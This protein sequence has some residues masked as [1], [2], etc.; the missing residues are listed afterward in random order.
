MDDKIKDEEMLD[1]QAAAAF[2]NVSP[3]TLSVWRSTGRYALPFLKIGR[4]VRY[5]RADLQ[6]WMARHT[7]SQTNTDEMVKN[8][9]QD[10]L[11][12]LK[13]ML[14]ASD[15]FEEACAHQEACE[16]IFKATGKQW[17]DD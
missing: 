13:N 6:A 5:R 10:L 4:K 16:A 3:G 11:K 14:N 15:A 9:A 1:D 8:A 2:L 17:M 12:A 7:H